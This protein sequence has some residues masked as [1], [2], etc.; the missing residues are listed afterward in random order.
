MYIKGKYKNAINPSTHITKTPKLI[1]KPPTHI[2]KTPTQLSK[3]PEFTNPPHTKKNT[4]YKTHTYTQPHV[5][6]TTHTH[7][8]ILYG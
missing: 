2:T 3:D 5:S 1:T 4:H 7:T 8:H 6:K